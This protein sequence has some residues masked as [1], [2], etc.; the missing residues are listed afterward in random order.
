MKHVN[1]DMM[2]LHN[3][4]HEKRSRSCVCVLHVLAQHRR[5]VQKFNSRGRFFVTYV[6]YETCKLCFLHLKE[7][8]CGNNGLKQRHTLYGGKN[9]KLTRGC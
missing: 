1:Y 2:L 5:L 7:M 6:D 4:N 9:N 8:R 3:A